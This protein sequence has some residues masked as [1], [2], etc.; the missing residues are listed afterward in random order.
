MRFTPA[1]IDTIKRLR[2]SKFP[3]PVVAKE[4]KATI[5]ECRT[6]VELPTY[7]TPEPQ[8][9]PWYVAQQTLPFGQ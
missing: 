5:L 7:L 6:A 8:T 2:R 3:W 4:L 9:L 1:Q